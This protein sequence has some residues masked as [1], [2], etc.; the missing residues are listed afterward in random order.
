MKIIYISFIFACL[1]YADNNQSRGDINTTTKQQLT[2]KQVKE[3]MARE[4]KYAK[5][6]KF[7]MGEGYNLKEKEFSPETLSHIKAIEVDD[8]DMDD[9]YN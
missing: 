3:Q 5:E 4:S 9:V 8:M 6:Q 2:Q 1:T 7:E